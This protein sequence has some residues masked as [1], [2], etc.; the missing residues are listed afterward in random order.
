MKC[1]YC[2]NEMPIHARF[3]ANCGARLGEVSPYQA[4]PT[5]QN[6]SW[7]C[8]L[9]L[10]ILI[11]ACGLFAVFGAGVLVYFRF[12][13]GLPAI[14]EWGS[15][16]VQPQT[17][18]VL[19][20]QGGEIAC[21]GARIIV[22]TGT[23]TQQA[24]FSASAVASPPVLPEEFLVS[25]AGPAYEINMSS[26]QELNG[27]IEIVLPLERQSGVDDALYTVFQ[28]DD[29]VWQDA[30]GQVE[31]NYIHVY[32][33]HFST[34]QPVIGYYQRRP[35]GFVNYGPY[36]AGIRPW[37]F[38]P[39]YSDTPAPPP[40]V[41]TVSFPPDTPGLWPNPSRFLSLP[42]GD[43]TFCLDWTDGQDRDEDDYFDYYHG[44]T[45]LITL[46]ENLP[47]SLDL[48]LSV[49]I[50][51]TGGLPG[52]CGIPP[53]VTAADSDEQ[54]SGTPA[55][56]TGD[57]TVRL[58]WGTEDDLDLHVIDPNGAEIYYS[59]RTSPSGGQ[60]DRDAN[61]GCGSLTTSPVEN[62]FWA[63]DTAPRGQY[64]V[65]VRYYSDCGERGPV[66]FRLRIV[67]DGRVV[68]DGSGTLDESGEEF[69]TT[70]T[71]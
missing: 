1:A 3:C 58:S 40:V 51:T 8:L 13:E 10:L 38:V 39:R 65:K 53:L 17:V 14:A 11:P 15:G 31:D 49:D 68:Y 21:S 50:N 59:N 62:V 16:G 7:P 19:D 69:A 67:A 33:T 47:T 32:V 24:E 30:G 45:N 5:P 36:S 61:P 42:L 4:P 43:Y 41:S 46:N 12:P 52:R 26:T 60:L 22:P 6:R 63:R 64:T 28:W 20:R 27:V 55:P 54:L 23:L 44:F 2:G 9:L 56:G 48:A 37:T 18:T 57:V 66:Q 70:F 25:A 35:V 34:F 29:G 71:R